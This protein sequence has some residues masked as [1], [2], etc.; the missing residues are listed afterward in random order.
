MHVKNDIASPLIMNTESFY[1]KV[2]DSKVCASIL[3]NAICGLHNGKYTK[4]QPVGN[5]GLRASIDHH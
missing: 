5:F 4:I 1:M 2:F 3:T